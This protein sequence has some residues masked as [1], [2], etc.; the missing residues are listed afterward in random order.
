VLNV[1]QTSTPSYA[2]TL[3]LDSG[4]DAIRIGATA[5]ATVTLS[6]TDS[7]L[8][9]PTSAVTLTT[10]GATVLVLRDG[11]PTTVTVQVGAVGAERTQILGGLS[12]G[13]T[14][15]V[16]DLTASSTSD[17]TTTGGLTNL[18]RAPDGRGGTGFVGGPGGR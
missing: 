4:T 12:Q 8:S 6:A 5:Q 13:E 18:V 2:V 11:V 16:A 10:T 3:A 17:D 7:A 1:S 14:V 9:V 15:V